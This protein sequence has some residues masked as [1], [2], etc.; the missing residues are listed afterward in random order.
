MKG[1][2]ERSTLEAAIGCRDSTEREGSRRAGMVKGPQ[3]RDNQREN[4]SCFAF[5]RILDR[6]DQLQGESHEN[7][8]NWCHKK[9]SGN[10]R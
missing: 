9:Q 8:D 2:L 1:R 6:N 5:P 7:K 4:Q 3:L 10:N